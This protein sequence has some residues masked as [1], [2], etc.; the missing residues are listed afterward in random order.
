MPPKAKKQQQVDTADQQ[1]AQ[2]E[3]KTAPD[4]LDL[5][6]DKKQKGRKG[7][8]EKDQHAATKNKRQ[9]KD[10]PLENTAETDAAVKMS[11]KST[12]NLDC[13]VIAGLLEESKVSSQAREPAGSRKSGAG[14]K[15]RNRTKVMPNVAAGDYLAD[16]D[17][18]EFKEAIA[19]LENGEV[20]ATCKQDGDDDA[21]DGKDS[22]LSADD[23]EDALS[24]SDE[25][26]SDDGDSE[27]ASAVKKKSTKQ[28][29]KV[30]K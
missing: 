11:T 19:R 25:E 14:R 21:S 1:V 24:D 15:G 17:D 23:L 2:E 8:K 4:A 30:E 10:A 20:A 29:S 13:S 28:P 16:S 12:L 22:D 6:S 27:E 26:A 9:K 3:A 5:S 18:E 7:K